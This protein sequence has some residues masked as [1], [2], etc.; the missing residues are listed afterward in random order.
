MDIEFIYLDTME[1]LRPKLTTHKTFVEA[2]RAV[3][4]RF[5]T[6]SIEQDGRLPSS[7]CSFK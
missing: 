2:A 5:E 4:E 1:A 3:E 6:G 7:F